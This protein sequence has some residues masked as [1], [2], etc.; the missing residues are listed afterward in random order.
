MVITFLRAGLF[1]FAPEFERFAGTLWRSCNIR[2]RVTPFLWYNICPVDGKDAGRRRRSWICKYEMIVAL[3]QKKI[4][5][6][7]RYVTVSSVP[8]YIFLELLSWYS[9][10]IHVA[11]IALEARFVTTINITI[12]HNIIRRYWKTI[13]AHFESVLVCERRGSF[14]WRET[15]SCLSC[16]FATQ[17]VVVT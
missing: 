12:E 5:I 16:Q 2:R 4:Q 17:F 8:K 1:L 7:R 6:K 3:K 10:S 14:S 11:M 15:G 9:I 13:N